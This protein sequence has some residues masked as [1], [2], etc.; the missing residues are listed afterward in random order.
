MEIKIWQTN[1][2]KYSKKWIKRTVKSWMKKIASSRYG[3]NESS[4]KGQLFDLL[5]R[6]DPEGNVRSSMSSLY[7]WNWLHQWPA[8]DWIVSSGPAMNR[9][10]DKLHGRCPV[11]GR[12][13]LGLGMG[14]RGLRATRLFGFHSL[15]KNPF[16]V[17]PPTLAPWSTGFFP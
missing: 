4:R 10:K 3:F 13:E 7:R 16:Q 15:Q 8:T 2:Q 14:Y 1:Q 9:Q 5:F 12:D 6:A 11:S 17:D